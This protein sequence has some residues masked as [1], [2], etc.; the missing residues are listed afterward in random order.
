[1]KIAVVGSRS[2]DDPKFMA[3]ILRH[4]DITVLISG[5]AKGADYYGKLYAFE[6]QILYREYPADWDRFGKTAG[7]LRNKQIVADCEMVIAF[8]DKQSRGTKLCIDLAEA[9]GKEVHVY[10][11]TIDDL[12][13]QIG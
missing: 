13:K 1:M 8:W 12:L 3:H 9:D 2:F 11:P 10:W 6:H 5:G 7:F 4:Y